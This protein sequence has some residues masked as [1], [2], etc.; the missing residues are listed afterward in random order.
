MFYVIYPEPKFIKNLGSKMQVTNSR[1]KTIK[2]IGKGAYGEIMLAEDL[3]H[4][5]STQ[6]QVQKSHQSKES[7][8]AEEL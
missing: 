3:K 2:V 4:R 6:P 8:L 7:Q 5:K 1:Y